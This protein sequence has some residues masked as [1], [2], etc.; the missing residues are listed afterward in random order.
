MYWLDELVSGA[1][2]SRIKMQG[3]AKLSLLSYQGIDEELAWAL[4]AYEARGVDASQLK[5][6]HDV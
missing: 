6:L 4:D 2:I 3:A 5:P 1:G